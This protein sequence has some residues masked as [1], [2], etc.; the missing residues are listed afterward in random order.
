MGYKGKVYKFGNDINTD[1]IIPAR[2]LNTIDKAELA[3]HCMEDADKAFASKVKH[4]DIIV[5]GK[6]FGCGSSRE[7]APIS[8]KAAG[9]SCVIAENFARIF[10]RNSINIGLPIV[11]SKEASEKIKAGDQVV[12]DTAAGVIKDM[13]TKETFKIEKYPAFMQ[14][15]IRAGG[16]M[17]YISKR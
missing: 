8:I 1:E 12:V 9:V 13:T 15:L 17:S 3:K 4:G 7:H 11:E 6:N 5:A 16:L 2:Y 10:F 14:K